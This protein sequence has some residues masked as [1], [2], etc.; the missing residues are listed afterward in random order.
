MPDINVN[1]QNKWGTTALI[2]ASKR[3]HTDIVKL[4]L[5]VPSIDVNVQN[6]FYGETA[7]SI[8]SKNGHTD[9]VKLIKN[10]KHKRRIRGVARTI[11]KTR[12][13]QV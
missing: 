5:A 12:Q 3:G 7:L 6:K 13:A 1:L 11:P 9:I 2:I 4:L 8:A 10:H